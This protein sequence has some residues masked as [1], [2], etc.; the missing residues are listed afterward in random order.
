MHAADSTSTTPTT[1]APE[2]ATS[3]NLP[4]INLMPSATIKEAPACIR[5]AAEAASAA[6]DEGVDVHS[7]ALDPYNPYP[8]I[9]A[10]PKAFHKLQ[11]GHL[12]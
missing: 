4:N 9:E 10:K 12:Y 11:G 2:I 3:S 6:Y 7:N 5:T 8:H 1:L